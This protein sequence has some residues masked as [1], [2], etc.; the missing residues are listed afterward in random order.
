ME[1]IYLITVW[2]GGK[3]ARKWKALEAPEVLPQGTG[4]TFQCL[5]TKL[6]VRVIGNISVEEFEQGA[7]AG[8]DIFGLAP[9][10]KPNPAPPASPG[11]LDP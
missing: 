7:E 5:D 10:I 4:V 2:S 3:A 6:N 8:E 11:L 1:T 9:G